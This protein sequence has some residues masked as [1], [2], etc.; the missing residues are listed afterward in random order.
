MELFGL[1]ITRKKDPADELKSFVPPVNDDGSI[2]VVTGGAQSIYVDMDGVAKTEAELVNRYRSMLLQPEVSSAVDD[3]INE[4]INVTEDKQPV[5]AVTDDLKVPD[6]VK[7]KIREEFNTILKLLDFSNVGYDTFMKWYVD[8]RVYYHAIIDD[9]NP[10]AGIQELRYIDPRKIRKVREYERDR[11]QQGTDFTV[12]KV[13][14][15]YYVYSDRGFD[16]NSTQTMASIEPIQ[17][18][19]ISKDAIVQSNSGLLNEKNTIVIGHLQKAYKPLNQLRMMEDASV[20]YRI[21]RAPE[22]RIFYIDVGN[23]PKI[24]AEQ[25]L[26]EMMTNHKNKMT[27]DSSTGEMIDQRKFMTITD[28]FWLPRREGNKGTEITT[29]PGGQNLGELDDILYFQKKLYKSLN[30]PISR[31][32]SEGG[33]SLGRSSEISRD[34]VKFSKFVRR[35]RVRFSMLF[36]QA[37][38][39]QLVLKGIIR[40]EEWQGIKDDLRYTF[41]MDNHFEE[42]KETE[43]LQNRLAILDSVD[44]Y[45]GKYFSMD[46]VRKN[47]LRMSEDDIKDQDKQMEQEFLENPPDGGAMGGAPDGSESGPFPQEQPEQGEP[48]VGKRPN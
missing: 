48:N 23:L 11:L 24:K 42:L 1:S 34:E 47:V 26:R 16:V 5:E 2:S 22:R 7:K 8:G 27:Y 21:S 4:A 10:K 37:L 45:V 41:Q 20:I 6:G 43:L 31:M 15:E 39:K 46:W 32:E 44:G 40:P 3:I 33:F 19:K 18:L 14:A 13:K 17:G 30:V 36:D 35:L 38:E 12:K 25:Y 29:L 9:A 28:D